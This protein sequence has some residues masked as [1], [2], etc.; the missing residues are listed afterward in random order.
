MHLALLPL[1]TALPVA[2]L[3]AG[4]G[5]DDGL[6]RSELEKSVSARM[7]D[8]SSAERG[9]PDS[10]R[11]AGGLDDEAQRCTATVGDQM[12]GLTVVPRDDEDRGWDWKFDPGLT[13]P[14]DDVATRLSAAI[15]QETHRL[16]DRVTCPEDLPGLP[17]A[18]MTCEIVSGSEQHRA[19]VTVTTA[20]GSDVAF[21]Y[22]I[23]GAS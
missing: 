17:D 18:T 4:C 12:I 9:S 2:L 7:D 23:E 22:E 16:L 5:G 21:R 1:L 20:D 8:E 11:C 19:R 13:L 10:V 15:T 14:A 3:A 6:D